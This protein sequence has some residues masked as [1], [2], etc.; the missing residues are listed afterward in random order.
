M[1][2]PG[3]GIR[4]HL[5]QGVKDDMND[6][7]I[8]LL[9]VSAHVIGLKQASLLLH[10]VDGLRV[11]LHIQPVAHVFAVS[12]DRKLLSVKRVVDD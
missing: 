9:I 12:V 5:P 11:V 2:F 10:H 1:R 7:N 6:L 8:L 4:K 3:I